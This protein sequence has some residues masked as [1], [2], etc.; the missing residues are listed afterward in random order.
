MASEQKSA[1]AMRYDKLAASVRWESYQL[2]KA[3]KE[4]LWTFPPLPET[5][6]GCGMQIY[7]RTI[8][9]KV[10]CV[11]VQSYDTIEVLKMKIEKA[12]GI[13][14]DQQRLV[15]A[16]KQLEDGRTLAD[17]NIQKEST[18]QLVMRLRGGMYHCTSGREDLKNM[19]STDDIDVDEEVARPRPSR[20]D[21]PARATSTASTRRSTASTR[22]WPGLLK[23]EI[24]CDL[25]F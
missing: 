14:P 8:T 5:R 16:G 9:G 21:S 2:A 10:M 19:D 18:V 12:E 13:P 25:S 20:R 24:R 23:F 22:D 1:R 3:D 4:E 15:F 17:Y 6:G 7:F 11:D